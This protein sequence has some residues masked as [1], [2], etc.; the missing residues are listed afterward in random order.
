MGCDERGGDALEGQDVVRSVECN[1][2][3]RLEG[4]GGV[5]E[6]NGNVECGGRGW[7]RWEG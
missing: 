1:V 3:G 7:M 5:A 4:R 6:Y 2:R